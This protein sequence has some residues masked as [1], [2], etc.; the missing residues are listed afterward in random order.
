MIDNFPSVHFRM[1]SGMDR[2]ARVNLLFSVEAP[3]RILQA[4][5]PYVDEK[6]R[7][8][9][10][11]MLS[12]PLS[13]EPKRPADPELR[14]ADDPPLLFVEYDDEDRP[15]L[16]ELLRLLSQLERNN[17]LRIFSRLNLRPGDEWQPILDAKLQQ[18]SIIVPIISSDL[19]A[20]P[21]FEAFAKQAHRLAREGRIVVPLLARPALWEQTQLGLLEPLPADRRFLS[22]RSRSEREAALVDIAQALSRA[23]EAVSK[24]VQTP[25]QR[26]ELLAPPPEPATA[27]QRPLDAPPPARPIYALDKIFPLTAGKLPKHNLVEPEEIFKLRDHLR[28][29]GLGLIVEGPSGIG[30]TTAVRHALALL[31]QELG[32]GMPR[33][34]WIKSR[35]PGDLQQLKKILVTGLSGG[36]LIIDDFHR[37][38]AELRAQVADLIK[39]VAD[40]EAQ[41]AK[42]TIIGINP[43]G[44]SLLSSG[45]DLKGRYEKETLRRQPAHKIRELIERGEQAANIRFE[46]KERIVEESHGCFFIAQMLCFYTAQKDGITDTWPLAQPKNVSLT[47]DYAIDRVQQQLDDSFCEPLR[48]FASF[49]CPE[50]VGPRGATLA[51]LYLLHASTRDSVNDS[52]RGTTS[53]SAAE[54]RFPILGPGLRWLAEGDR[55]A[56]LFEE[57]PADTE[58]AGRKKASLREILYYNAGTLSAEDPQLFYYLTRLGWPAFIRDTGHDLAAVSWSRNEGLTFRSEPRKPSAVVRIPDSAEP[59]QPVLDLPQSFFLH[60]SDL[61]FQSAK[62]VT[63]FIDALEADLQDLA[64]LVPRLDGVVLSGDLTQVAEHAEFAAAEDFL[65]ELRSIYK[66]APQQVVLV[67]GNH[68]GSWTW[69]RT[70]YPDP[71]PPNP[72]PD[73]AA[74]RKRFEA[75]ADFHQSVLGLPYP[76][77]FER[78]AT[79]HPFGAQKVLFLGLNS[80]WQCDHLPAHRGRATINEV[81]LANALRTVRREPAY[82]D[83]LKIAVW[84]HPVQSDGEDRIKNTGF[85]D[86]MAQAGFRLGMHGHMHT[87]QLHQHAYDVT[88]NGRQLRLLGAGTFGAPTAEWRSGVPL[89]YQILCINKACVKVLS[90]CRDNPEGPWRG[91]GRWVAGTEARTYYEIEL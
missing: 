33:S 82:A 21:R 8:A 11:S 50:A 23:A 54:N 86:R 77:D 44:A 76:L 67:P 12:V 69:S 52:L 41:D 90:R 89:Q 43:V 60:L 20:Q 62:Q 68:D 84:H 31:S 46:H 87:A 70:A 25:R 3:E 16:T 39:V 1:S 14:S 24:P 19:L 53:L 28:T 75:F 55:L 83:W 13:A 30:K 48:D 58:A 79:L 64:P 57:R 59:R 61:H 27:G 45:M 71:L 56:D 22:S 66:L 34:I 72:Q 91:D 40:S 47:A 7:R 73:E 15:L 32:A 29:L 18:A 51:L 4:L 78:Q 37:L 6:G 81:A 5:Y 80:A 38:P 49:S 9:L 2:S 17:V 88:A 35:D 85:L 65:R 36:H 63:P 42:V 74:Y 26:S 10:D